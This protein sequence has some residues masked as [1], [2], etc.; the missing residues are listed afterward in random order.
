MSHLIA[1]PQDFRQADGT[2]FR[3]P[4]R[5]DENNLVLRKDSD[6]S[7]LI[8]TDGTALLEMR[9]AS[10]PEVM[11]NFLN[12][13]FKVA[14]QRKAL[15]I[16]AKEDI[17]PEWDMSIEDSAQA[18][19]IFRAMNT[20]LD[21]VFELEKAPYEWLLQQVATWGIDRLGINAAV[22]RSV[23]QGAHQSATTRPE[24]RRQSARN[25]KEKEMVTP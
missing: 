21:G 11:K 7:V 12:A 1:V 22:F 13:I 17:R 4:V 16:K 23:I 10:F 24:R 25:G 5:D 2:P 18:I 19:D 14:E 15:A 9:E 3:V 6:G 8:G 20:A